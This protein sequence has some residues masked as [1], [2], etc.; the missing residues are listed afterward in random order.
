MKIRSTAWCV[1]AAFVL[2]ASA[3]CSPA[4]KSPEAQVRAVF[5]RAEIAAEARDLGAFK[6][7]IAENYQDAEG[8]D[9][10]AIEGIVRYYFLGHQSIHLYM[11]VRGIAFSEPNRAQAELL[12]AM[13]GEPIGGAENLR[14]LRADLHRFDVTLAREQDGEWKV[15]AASWR[16]AE[17]VDFL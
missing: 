6:R 10:R 2:G 7:H 16:R 12:V 8:Q 11:R 13:A 17:P 15:I 9:K 14:R 4:P 5:E 3:A 1:A